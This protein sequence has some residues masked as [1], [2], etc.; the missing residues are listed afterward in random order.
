MT[1]MKIGLIFL[2]LLAS[3]SEPVR[4]STSSA[5]QTDA[6]MLKFEKI[7]DDFKAQQKQCPGLLKRLDNESKKLSKNR[8]NNLTPHFYGYP[9]EVG[10]GRCLEA[11]GRTQEAFARYRAVYERTISDDLL[12]FNPRRWP[13]I[14]KFC[15]RTAEQLG[16]DSAAHYQVLAKFHGATQNLPFGL[17]PDEKVRIMA[18]KY[19]TAD[20]RYFSA[21]NDTELLRAGETRNRAV[22]FL[23]GEADRLR[24]TKSQGVQ[25]TNPDPVQVAQEEARRESERQKTRE[26]FARLNAQIAGQTAATM[27]RVRRESQGAQARAESEQAINAAKA[28]AV[29]EAQIAQTDAKARREFEQLVAADNARVAANAAAAARNA[30]IA[31]QQSAAT[32][33][34]NAAGDA[35]NKRALSLNSYRWDSV[36]FPINDGRARTF[37]I[38][39]SSGNAVLRASVTFGE[40]SIKGNQ[41]SNGRFRVTA[42]NHSNCTIYVNGS[43]ISR[44]SGSPLSMIDLG[45]GMRVQPRQKAEGSKGISWDTKEEYDFK[46]DPADVNCVQ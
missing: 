19:S 5:S 21:E 33:A 20:L 31:A 8:G 32:A 41:W 2:C 39:D 7:Q 9:A 24:L 18:Q 11:Q 3:H 4:G 40:G 34:R 29:H 13:E 1:D 17:D 23:A 28:K 12:T 16:I 27:D 26:H 43:V 15:A 44:K 42:E 38:L 25:Q 46:P 35:G 14:L 45:R 22:K 6:L 37:H 36:R 10:V 30:E